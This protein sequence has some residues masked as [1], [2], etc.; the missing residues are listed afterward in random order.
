[1]LE[2]IPSMRFWPEGSGE[3]RWVLREPGKQY[4]AYCGPNASRELDLTHDQARFNLYAVELKTGALKKTGTTVAAGSTA[5]L[6]LVEN[7]ENVFWLRSE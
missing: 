7:E 4:L 5:R 6:P 2:A 3:R 1:L